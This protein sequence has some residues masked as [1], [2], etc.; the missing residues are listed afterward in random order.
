[1]NE[2]SQIGAIGLKQLETLL[3]MLLA[4]PALLDSLSVLERQ[5]LEAARE[6]VQSLLLRARLDGPND[7]N[8]N[9]S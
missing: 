7:A 4:S 1:M 9:E 5:E 8:P 3:A 2:P 6:T